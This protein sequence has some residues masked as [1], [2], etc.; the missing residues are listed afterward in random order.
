M[1]YAVDLTT[2]VDARF[3]AIPPTRGAFSVRRG[4]FVVCAMILLGLAL[5]GL[6]LGVRYRSGDRALQFWTTPIALQIAQAPQAEVWR[7]SSQP[8]APELRPPITHEGQTWH[9]SAAWN[10]PNAVG[11]AHARHALLEDASFN[12]SPSE[13]TKP[14]WQY[15][16]RLSG[17]GEPTIL[18]FDL[19]GAR[20]AIAGRAGSLSMAPLAPKLRIF[21]D[22]VCS[23]P[24]AG[25]V[26][27]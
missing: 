21:F 6:S 2:A 15:A 7:L 18:L 9:V 26:A 10:L 14:N 27:K 25:L 23:K 5:A 17:Q 11:F 24:Q 16:V 13:D 8:T 3:I 4:T 1:A 19:E 22:D 20:A 12:W